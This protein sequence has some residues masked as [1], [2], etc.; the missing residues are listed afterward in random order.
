MATV[1]HEVLNLGCGNAHIPDAVNVDISDGCN[2]D[3]VHDLRITPWPF[4]DDTFDEVWCHDI[5]EHLPD[6]VATMDEI[7]RV[8][9]DGAVLYITTPHFSCVNAFSDPT[10]CHQFG[11]STFDFFTDAA[12]TRYT[13]RLFAYRRHILVFEPTRKN[14]LIRRVANRWPRFYEWHLCWIF[15]AFFISTELVVRK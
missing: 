8:S 10:H 13:N 6:T 9:K 2:P 14:S 15:P 1:R 11:M 4:P 3:V 5:V 12:T 7:H